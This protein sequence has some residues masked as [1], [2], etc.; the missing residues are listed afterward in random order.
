MKK[1]HF[2]PDVQEFLFLLNKY[3]VKYVIVGGEAVIYYG[4][5]RLTGDVDFFYDLAYE[6]NEKLFSALWEFWGGDIP[7]IKDKKDLMEAGL[8]LQFGVVP[9]RIDLLNRIDNVDFNEAW[10][11]RQKEFVMIRGEKISVNYIGI[12]QL[13][14]NKEAIGRNKDLDDLKY[15]KKVKPE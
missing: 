11:N 4:Y 5:A 8:I 9:N 13:I 7:G 12:D 14:K 3:S 6:N 15:L 2:S 1:A 10:L